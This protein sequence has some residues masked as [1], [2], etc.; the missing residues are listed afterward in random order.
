[1]AESDYLWEG[2]PQ[3]RQAENFRYGTDSV[4]L[5]NFT[6]VSG[7][8]R[9]IDLG[10]ASGVITLLLLTRSQKLHMTGLEIDPEAAGTAQENMLRNGYG[11]RSSIVCGDIRNC[12][13]FFK[14]GSFDMVVAN[15]PYFPISAGAVAK[16][17]RRAAARGEVKCTLEDLC[18]AAE[19]LCRWDGKF[20]AVYR[21]ERLPEL[22]AAMTN[23][24]IEPKRMR[25]VCHD[26]KSAP[27]LVLVE[28]R[29]GGA[30][31]LKMEKALIMNDSDGKY[32]EEMRAIYH[33]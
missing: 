5:G 31:G 9:G 14:A 22:F 26:A 13:E 27:S 12:R 8:R 18:C 19:Y 6:S 17:S 11:E 23:H 21:P 30:P 7:A 15:P 32:T 20:A 10:C 3:F 16:D 2:G 25:I 28:G 1:M 4:L 33:M 24:G 29:R